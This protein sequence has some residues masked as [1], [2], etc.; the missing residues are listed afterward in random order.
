MCGL[1][2]SMLAIV[3]TT[4]MFGIPG[5]F[6][7]FMADVVAWY[8]YIVILL[9][10]STNAKIRQSRVDQHL[11]E[12]HASLRH[13][14]REQQA[15]RRQQQEKPTVNNHTRTKDDIATERVKPNDLDV[16]TE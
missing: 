3:I 8:M 10:L 16:T 12:Q 11:E 2:M 1:V 9:P 13:V 4:S 15:R 5:A 14:M 7:G 6:L